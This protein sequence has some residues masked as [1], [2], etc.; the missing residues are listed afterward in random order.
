MGKTLNEDIKCPHCGE[1]IE[2]DVEQKKYKQLY[3]RYNQCRDAELD[4]FWKNSTF[5][6]VMMALCYTALGLLIS[7][8]CGFDCEKTESNTINESI[9]ES[10]KEKCEVALSVIS[11][12]GLILSKIWIWMAQGLK[13]W[14]EVYESA[15]WDIEEKDN[16][17]KFDKKYTI[18]NYWSIKRGRCR[19]FKSKRLSTSKIVILIG[20]LMGLVWLIS[21]TFALYNY[22]DCDL[23]DDKL[24]ENIY[25]RVSEY[26]NCVFWLIPA[27]I[28]GVIHLGLLLIRSS[29]LRSPYEQKIYNY[30][31]ND[32][33]IK[34]CK[35]YGYKLPYFEVKNGMLS[36]I[37]SNIEQF[38]KGKRFLSDYYRTESKDNKA[39]FKISFPQKK[40]E[41]HYKNEENIQTKEEKEISDYITEFDTTLKINTI[42]VYDKTISVYFNGSNYKDDMQKITDVFD[43]LMKKDTKYSKFKVL[44]SFKESKD[45]D[46]N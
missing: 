2:A 5:V 35:E 3:D 1:S 21:L 23:I 30:V 22:Y 25:Q 24:I 37:H 18:E 41:N 6:W 7:K 10:M 43:N 46:E 11:V 17:L 31:R 34:K 9:N 33:T 45:E 12:F 40:V 28:Y 26:K 38:D 8:Y 14:Y 27:L 39:E 16:I 13:A 15:I 4:R 20:R 32:S 29:A 44:Y 42:R 19:L 36:F